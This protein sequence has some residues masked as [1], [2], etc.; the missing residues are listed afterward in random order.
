MQ[1]AVMKILLDNNLCVLSTCKDDIPDSSLMLYI[2][3]N[4][5]TKLH[6]LTLRETNKYLN[7]ISNK[8]VSLLIDTRNTIQDKASQV[9]ALTVNGEACIVE[10]NDTSKRIIDQLV[11]KHDQLSNLAMNKSVCVI[12]VSIKSILFLENVD[13]ASN[14]I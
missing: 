13:K 11:K 7:I 6:M 5:C 10:D 14:V 9:M 8:H 3:D 1:S 4:R 2:C 12:E